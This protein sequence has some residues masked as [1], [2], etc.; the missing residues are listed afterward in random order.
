MAYV[1]L[2]SIPD[3]N[4]PCLPGYRY[5]RIVK[6]RLLHHSMPGVFITGLQ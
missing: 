4:N 3:E 6:Q 1:L 5:N 2:I